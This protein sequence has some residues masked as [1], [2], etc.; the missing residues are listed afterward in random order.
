LLPSSAVGLLI[1]IVGLLPG[2]SYTWAF[3]RQTGS[4]GVSLADRTFRFISVSLLFHLLLGWPEYWLYRIAFASSHNFRAGQF[5]AAWVG[6]LLVTSIPAIVG[7]AMGKLYL[8]QIKGVASKR[9]SFVLDSRLVRLLLG[10]ERAPRAWDNLFSE[11]PTFYVRLR[12]TNGSWLA[13]LFADQSYVGAYPNDG[14]LY[15]EQAWSLN[16]KMA[17]GPTS[18]GYSLYIPSNQ[19]AWLEIIRP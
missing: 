2:A 12:T 13:G 15:L 8:T 5:A 17:L 9:L 7:S 3:E 10:S 4:Y 19:I 11:R 16:D 18:L 14:D 6:A 1:L